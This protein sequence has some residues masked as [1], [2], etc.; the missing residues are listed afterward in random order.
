MDVAALVSAL[1]GTSSASYLAY[2]AGALA[3]RTRRSR[4]VYP[5]PVVAAAGC[6][7]RGRCR[8]ALVGHAIGDA[9]NLP[10]ER[11]PRWLVRARY[12]SGP[13]M[14]RGVLRFLRRAGD[15]S[16]DT[17]LA[18]AVARSIGDDG[19]YDRD[20]FVRE[21]AQWSR[22]RIGAGRAVTRAARRARRGRAGA[23]RSEGNGVAIRVVPLAIATCDEPVATLLR[24]VERNGLATHETEAAWRG[25]AFVA[26]L[27]RQALR[28]RPGVFADGRM[29]RDAIAAAA[30]RS[31]F[32]PKLPASGP[33]ATDA[34]LREAL[35]LTGTSAHVH[36]SVPAA[37]L[38]L[39]RHKLDFEA[40]MRAVFFG[41]G[42]T[43]SIGAMVGAVIGAQLGANGLP[44]EWVQAVQHRGYLCALADQLATRGP[45]ERLRSAC[46]RRDEAGSIDPSG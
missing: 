24:L 26:V 31:G 46:T 13:R 42:D 45:S 29:L 14:R 35:E 30:A 43:D 25:A 11:L 4:R 27:L 32:D 6:A 19:Q 18:I 9:L 20:R 36:Q 44:S 17:Q 33:I 10:A 1:V 37:A 39:L 8:G 23:V 28:R 2:R 40:A 3:V 5:E 38:V 21:L 12:R 22:I 15:V 7:W 16:D 34:E 41:G